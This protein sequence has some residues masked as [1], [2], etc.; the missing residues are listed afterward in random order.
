[1]SN[2][3]EN[4]QALQY[5]FDVARQAHVNAVIHDQVKAYATKLYTALTPQP[6]LAAAPASIAEAV[7]AA[8]Q[9]PASEAAAPAAS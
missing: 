1:M 6:Q 3:T 8:T 4:I 2:P 9:P 7:A 5:I